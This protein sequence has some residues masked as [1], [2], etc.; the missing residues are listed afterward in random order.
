MFDINLKNLTLENDLNWEE[1]IKITE[2]YSGSDIA[3]VCREAAF[4]GMRRRLLNNTTDIVN[5]VKIDNFKDELNTPIS[6][7]DVIDSIKN[8][9]KS[10]ATE[11]LERYIKWSKEF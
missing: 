9:S 4:M 7:K 11:D 10:V 3:N 1:I 5:L 2:G 6:Q 8:I